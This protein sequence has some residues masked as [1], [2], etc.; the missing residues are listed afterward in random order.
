MSILT[1]RQHELTVLLTSLLRPLPRSL[2]RKN[3][4]LLFPATPRTRWTAGKAVWPC[5]EFAFSLA[6]PAGDTGFVGA[7][8][9]PVR[10]VATTRLSPGFHT[11]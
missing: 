6:L 1:S 9:H 11:G 4:V 5:S 8:V 3:T 7:L 10:I 2:L